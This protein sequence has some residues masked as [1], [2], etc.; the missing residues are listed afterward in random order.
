MQKVKR[1]TK[2]FIAVII[3]AGVFYCLMTYLQENILT[4]PVLV[5][6]TTI[7][8][9]AAE[10]NLF[11]KILWIIGDMTEPNFY[12]SYLGGIGLLAGSMIAYALDKKN[13]K[14]KGFSIA[15]GSGLW[16]WVFIASFISLIISNIIYG[17]NLNN[18]WFPTFVPFVCVGA[19]TVFI[20][21]GGWKNVLTGAILGALFTSP[22]SYMVITYVCVPTG[23]PGVIG[24]VAGMWIGSI[25]CFEIFK[26]LPWMK[27]PEAT[28]TEE[29]AVTSE[30]E[31]DPKRLHPNRFF[32]RRIIADFSE[33]VFASN[34]YVGMGIILG[35]LIS[36][37][38]CTLEPVYG[39]GILA[40]MIF[41][42]IL[43]GAVSVYV[44]WHH[45]ME[46]TW[47]PS[48][49]SMVSVAPGL[50]LF[51]GGSIPVAVIAAIL[52]GIICPPLADLV[53]RNIPKHWAPVVGTTF[54]MS[55]GTIVVAMFIICAKA[56]IPF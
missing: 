13:S 46:R 38:L 9:G 37:I 6:Y 3:F 21:G 30:T 35:T 24:S 23:L 51:Y 8:K 53:I 40:A 45:W 29:T 20:Y 26:L 36:W 12:K 44:Y 52:G 39:A 31:I 55:L 7:E 2:T 27:L 49:P 54:S 1:P 14:F 18:G 4:I 22:I 33:P 28:G 47:F 48:F 32:V 5:N 41:S 16:P 25:I 10:N 11:Y 15:Y 34:E 50:T 19:A 43:T 56:V 42:Q 17:N